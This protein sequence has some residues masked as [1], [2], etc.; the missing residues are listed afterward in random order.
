M[1]CLGSLQPRARGGV[2]AFVQ[3]FEQLVSGLPN[4]ERA[5]AKSRLRTPDKEVQ[6]ALDNVSRMRPQASDVLPLLKKLAEDH[7]EYRRSVQKV[8]AEL[9]AKQ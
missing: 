8:V 1:N 7:A 5:D 2:K 9:E 3:Y 6:T 4:S